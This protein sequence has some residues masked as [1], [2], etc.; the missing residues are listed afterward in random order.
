[1]ANSVHKEKSNFAQTCNL[2]SQ[3]LKGRGSLG[4]ISQLGI[5]GKIES[6]GS[7]TSRPPATTMNLLPNLENSPLSN[8]KSMDFFTKFTGFASSTSDEGTANGSDSKKPSAA[9]PASAPMTIFYGGQVIVV[10]EFPA[11]KAKEIM[12]LAGSSHGFVEKTSSTN[13]VAS[14][15]KNTVQDR[16]ELRPQ[17]PKASLLRF[18]EKRKERIAAKAPYQVRDPKPSAQKPV[19]S[20][21]P[22]LEL[23]DQ[24][25]K[26]LELKL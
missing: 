22:W 11:D 23:E 14:E 4:D 12:D 7:E 16:F 19:E 6:K 1:M 10:N 5:G 17:A 2:L 8:T 9:S 15:S 21:N 13:S 25:S 20:S 26:Q 3:Y 18:F 24:S